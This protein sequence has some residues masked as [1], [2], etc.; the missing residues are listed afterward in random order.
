MRGVFFFSISVA[1]DVGL[2]DGYCEPLEA[3]VLPVELY[4][5]RKAVVLVE[6]YAHYPRPRMVVQIVLFEALVVIEHLIYAFTVHVVDFPGVNAVVP[7]FFDLLILIQTT[8]SRAS[9]GFAP[10]SLPEL[11]KLS[12]FGHA[13]GFLKLAFRNLNVMELFEQPDDF[14][15]G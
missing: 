5:Q 7:D 12:S 13:E 10:G 14:I 6:D 2:A 1:L 4:R 9:W 11:K 8:T 15:G 3:V